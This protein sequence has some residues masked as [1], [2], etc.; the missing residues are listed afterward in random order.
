MVGELGEGVRKQKDEET[1]PQGSPDP[2]WSR[3]TLGANSGGPFGA[4]TGAQ[5]TEPADLNSIQRAT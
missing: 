5:K 1:S 2:R 4:H 3:Q